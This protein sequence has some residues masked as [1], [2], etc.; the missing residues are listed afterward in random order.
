MLSP[1]LSEAVGLQPG[2]LPA[3]WGTIGAIA[4][5]LGLPLWWI[6]APALSTETASADCE[7]AKN[8]TPN[9]GDVGL[10]TFA[11]KS[12]VAALCVYYFS[13][14]GAEH[15]LGDWL[16]AFTVDTLDRSDDDGANVTAVYWGMLTLGRLL[17]AFTTQII[18]AADLIAI[19][20]ALCG[21]GCAVILMSETIAGAFAAA[22]LIGIGLSTLYPMGIMLAER[23]L[24]VTEGWISIFISGGTIGSVVLPT[25]VGV[26]L[27]IASTSLGWTMSAFVTTQLMAYVYVNNYK[28]L[29]RVDHRASS[30]A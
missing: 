19:D 20:F 25:I 1:V 26:L 14:A 7:N 18:S 9:L 21:I 13:Y 22:S 6:P 16:T 11:F 2:Q 10:S 12:A 24:P 17:G 15:T 3:T 28:D 5:I 8:K 30:T 27:S 4:A 23:K 29:I